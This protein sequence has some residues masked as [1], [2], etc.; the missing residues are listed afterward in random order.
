MRPKKRLGQHFL[1]NVN[2]ARRI[3]A[4]LDSDPALPILEIGGG[5]GDLTIHLLAGGALVTCVEFDSDMI[6]VLTERFTAAKNLRLLRSDILEFNLA[7]HFDSGQQIRLV[8][9][10]PYNITSAILK[11]IVDNRANFPQAVIMI[12]SEVADR[13]AATPGGKDFGSLT[14]FVQLFFT[15]E[16]LFELK[17]GSFLP[18][19]KVSSTVLKLTR[20]AKPLVESADFPA[21]RRLTSACFRWRRKQLI[22]I[23]RDE[24]SLGQPA[25]ES[26]LERLRIDPTLRPEQL[27]VESFVALSGQLSCLM[28]AEG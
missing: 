21:L 16:K 5:R 1:V 24:Y 8:G 9:N 4:A 11:W 27:P 26:L 19:P 23:L 28:K 17:A 14:V 22:R 3:A 6:A 10:L 2:A 12:Q 13:V 7:D 18:P 15:V 25:L 20:R